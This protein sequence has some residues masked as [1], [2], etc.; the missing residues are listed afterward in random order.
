MTTAEHPR[1]RGGQ[2][3]GRRRQRHSCCSSSRI[4]LGGALLAI[5][6]T[7]A[8]AVAADR[9]PPPPPPP[10]ADERFTEE[11]LLR[12]LPSGH[13][14]ALF[15]FESAAPE[16]AHHS[17]F[18]RAAAQLLAA[19]PAARRVD[20]SLAAGRWRAS[21]WGAA[22]FE[23][24]PG[25]AELRAAFDVG[26]AVE[27]YLEEEEVEA[28][29]ACSPPSSDDALAD[30]ALRR[31]WSSL[32]HGL[33]GLLCASLNFVARPEATAREVDLLLEEGEGEEEQEGG[34]GQAKMRRR[35]QRQRWARMRASLP[36]E[37]VCTENLTPWLKLLPCRDAQG[38]ASLLRARPAVFAAEYHA[39]SVSLRVEEEEEGEGRRMVLTQRLALVLRPLAAPAGGAPAARPPP[40]PGRWSDWSLAATLAAEG[41]LAGGSCPQAALSRVYVQQ[42][43]EVAAAGAGAATA[44]QMALSPP[45]HGELDG[46]RVAAAAVGVGPAASRSSRIFWYDADQLAAEAAKAAAASA[47]DDQGEDATAAAPAADVALAWEQHTAPA[48]VT[49]L[50][51]RWTARTYTTGATM[52]KGTLVLELERAAAAAAVS[53]GGGQGSAGR[54]NNSDTVCVSLVVPWFVRVWVH[55]LELSL[56]GRRA[57]LDAHTAARRVRPASARA[58]PLALDLCL[59]L[60]RGGLAAT[61]ATTARLSAAFSTGFMTVFEFPPDAHRGVD[62]PAARLTW[63]EEEEQ[64]EEEESEGASLSS[65]LSPLLASLAQ[66]RPSAAYS[67][68]GALVAL[69]PPDFSMPY[70]VVCLTSTVLAVYV[71]AS[72]NAILR[73][74]KKRKK[75]KSGGDSDSGSE[76]DDD[77][78][79]DEAARVARRRARKKRRVARVLAFGLL[80]AVLALWIDPELRSSCLA[81][82]PEGMRPKSAAEQAAA[83]FARVGG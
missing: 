4:V 64:E 14:L 10:G 3:R 68:S 15:H 48:P 38:L 59:V 55:T 13:L 45:P 32:A 17:R 78:E 35:R 40:A 51:P 57:D 73:R 80:F 70:N 1:R 29:A 11:L 61:T 23:A 72:V 20:L 66:P 37:A 41:A 8:T 27:Q 44:A 65:S 24:K 74:P 25:G 2:P 22:P 19:A 31:A 9:S 21:A 83:A 53:G 62:V 12:P 18:P 16:R 43:P 49:P 71:G 60:L 54:N 58:A 47:T 67:E 36:R 52:A 76:S 30:A 56:D 33:S 50:Q 81:L 26:A 69:A 79:G 5:A 28:A 34:E 7:A 46:F 82:L 42:P 39:L 75:N 63:L 6:A 77:E